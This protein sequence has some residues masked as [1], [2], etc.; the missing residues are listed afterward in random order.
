ME[1]Q[2]IR[3]NSKVEVTGATDVDTAWDAAEEFL[4][5]Q[6]DNYSTGQPGGYE[7]DNA[8]DEDGVFVF[9]VK[10]Y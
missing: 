6:G 7:I 4:Q 2:F 3:N 9:P 5:Q 1:V 8:T 10:E